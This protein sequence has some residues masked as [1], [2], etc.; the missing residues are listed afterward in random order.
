M[1]KVIPI[2]TKVFKREQNLVEFIIKALSQKKLSDGDVIC[3]TSKIVSLAE[4]RIVLKKNVKSKKDLIQKEADVYIGDSL[5][6]HHITIK[7]NLLIPA[8]GIDESNADSEY[9]ILYPTDP[10]QSAKKIHQYLKTK[11]KLKK[12]GIILTDSHTTP[13]RRGVT[14]I[15]IAHCG[16]HGLQSYVGKKDLFG[17]KLKFTHVNIVDS[18]ASM[19]VYFMGESNESKPIV[20]IKNAKVKF[21]SKNV[22]NEIAVSA[23]EDIYLAAML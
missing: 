4:N 19:A 1:F 16:F 8:A 18:L 12:L 2:K 14:G 13:L 6:N 17:K 10:Y 23:K 22:K 11:F 20:I 3:I 9:Y 5:Y 21:T 15:S 7:N